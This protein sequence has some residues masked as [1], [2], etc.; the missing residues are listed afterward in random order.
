MTRDMYSYNCKCTHAG[1]QAFHS[2]RQ[3]HF[4][5]H[6][7]STHLSLIPTH[8]LSMYLPVLTDTEADTQSDHQY[9][10]SSAI[11][12]LYNPPMYTCQL[13][14]PSP[15]Y[16]IFVRKHLCLLIHINSSTR[17]QA[18]IWTLSCS[19]L[20]TSPTNNVSN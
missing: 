3:S 14:H 16:T 12:S 18:I 9:T 17:V 10:L 5:S 2:L 4:Q 1:M 20:L 15:P 13:C 6:I 11:H 19:Y 8:K 7:Q